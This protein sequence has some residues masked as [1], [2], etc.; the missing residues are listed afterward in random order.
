MPAAYVCSISNQLLLETFH[1]PGSNGFVYEFSEGCEHILLSTCDPV[2]EIEIRIDYLH[3]NFSSGLIF[4]SYKDQKVVIDENNAIKQL[5]PDHPNIVVNNENDV[6]NINLTGSGISLA[7]GMSFLN[8]YFDGFS[9]SFL[10][11]INGLCGSLDGELL[12]KDCKEVANVSDGT[13]VDNFIDSYKVKQT[14]LVLRPQRMECG[15]QTT[16]LY[17]LKYNCI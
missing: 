2:M 10:P 12:L 6:L 7:L 3:S 17:S 1:L 15:M 14:E 11:F 16:P 13:A 4:V 8:V 5:T 9:A